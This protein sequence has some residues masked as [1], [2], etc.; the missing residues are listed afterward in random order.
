MVIDKKIN[1]KILFAPWA[2]ENER[3]HSHQMWYTPIKDI[4]KEMIVFDPQKVINQYGRKEMNF[5]FIELLKKEKPDYIFIWLIWE[6]FYP[7]TLMSIKKILPNSKVVNFCGDDDIKFDNYTTPYLPLI[8]YTLATQGNFFSLYKKYGARFFNALGT[9]TKK[10]FPIKGTKKKYDVSFLGTDKAD[11]LEYARHLLKNKI[12]F[13]ICGAGWDKY[14]EFKDVW[15][16][17]VSDEEFRIIMNETRI[18]VCFS[19][20]YFN[21]PHAIER[22]LMANACKSFVLTEYAPGY[23]PEFTEK[24]NIVTFKDKNELID[25]IKYYLKNEKEREEIAKNAYE[26]TKKGFS[27]EHLLYSAFTQMEKDKIKSEPFDEKYIYLDKYD[28]QRD[29]KIIEEV[30]K[31]KEYI[32]FKTKRSKGLKYKE[33]FQT[34]TLRRTQKDMCLCNSFMHSGLIGDYMSLDLFYAYDYL[35]KKYFYEHAD[36]G[37]LCVKRDYFLENI[38]KFKKSM[39]GNNLDFVNKK[40][41]SMISISLNRSTKKKIIPVNENNEHIL[42]SDLSEE[43]K[44]LRNNGRLF[45]D[46]YLYKLLIYSLFFNNS[47]LKFLVKTVVPQSKNERFIKFSNFFK[48]YLS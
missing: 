29:I 48:K 26:K 6:E 17:K 23:Y 31:G 34:Q 28:L 16:G 7:E 21:V 19:K 22:F 13:A 44:V 11:R 38:E 3:W 14:P 30:T 45:K 1:K 39:A 10:F 47:L 35:D 40:N 25:K 41:T 42:F 18:N 4:F 36:L 24:K 33:F 12:N 37:Q 32:F 5:R 20:N 15:K 9:D 2:A 46:S 8:D 43:L 27:N